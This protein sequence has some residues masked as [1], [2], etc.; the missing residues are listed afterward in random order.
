MFDI[1]YLT[2]G[3]MLRYH[4]PIIAALYGFNGNSSEIHCHRSLFVDKEDTLGRFI[5]PTIICV[6][7][8]EQL[9]G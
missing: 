4:P 3:P 6:P 1:Y 5:T 7:C 2:M 9:P 8:H